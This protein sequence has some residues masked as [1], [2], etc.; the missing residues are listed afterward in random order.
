MVQSEPGSEPGGFEEQMWNF[1]VSLANKA[2]NECNG[3]KSLAA[4]RLRVS[5]AYL[6]RLIRMASTPESTDAA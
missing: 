4:R 6:H 2:I 3:N 5:R 1:K